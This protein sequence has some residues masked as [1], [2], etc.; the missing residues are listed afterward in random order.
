LPETARAVLR[1][2]R[3]PWQQPRFWLG[4]SGIVL[5][6]PVLRYFDAPLSIIG[7]LCGLGLAGFAYATDPTAR[8]VFANPRLTSKK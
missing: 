4:L 3:W 7:L 6:A 8:R 5:L 1:E 2:Q